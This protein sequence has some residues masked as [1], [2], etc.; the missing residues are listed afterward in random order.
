M[1]HAEARSHIRYAFNVWEARSVRA[2]TL[3]LSIL[4]DA[5]VTLQRPPRAGERRGVA[6]ATLAAERGIPRPATADAGEIVA[7]IAVER[8]IALPA[9]TPAATRSASSAAEPAPPRTSAV[10]DP[11]EAAEPS[12]LRR[13]F[14]RGR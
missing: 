2:W 9:D 5:G 7:R 11:R 6:A 10:P 14:R 8:G 1:S 13:I 3:D 4:T 12:L